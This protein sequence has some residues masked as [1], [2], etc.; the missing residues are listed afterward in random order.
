MLIGIGAQILWAP[1]RGLTF[2]L[3]AV[4]AEI[5]LAAKRGLCSQRL[6][7]SRFARQANGVI[8]VTPAVIPVRSISYAT[9]SSCLSTKPA[10]CSEW[11]ACRRT[12]VINQ[13][14]Q[15]HQMTWSG[16]TVIN[17]PPVSPPGQLFCLTGA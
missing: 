1:L 5:R 8:A 12:L 4:D 17:H 16:V 7:D 2:A 3:P 15:L 13:P 14:F 10:S 6:P 11:G 9:V